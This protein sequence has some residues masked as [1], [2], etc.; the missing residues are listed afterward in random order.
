MQNRILIVVAVVLFLLAVLMGSAIFAV[1]YLTVEEPHT[2]IVAA[3][4][5]SPNT[6]LSETH[7]T[8][9]E[10]DEAPPADAI[11][12][13]R[14]L[15]GQVLVREVS[16][17]D[18]FF[19]DDLRSDY[20]VFKSIDSIPAGNRISGEMVEEEYVE[21]KPDRAVADL[22][23]LIDKMVRESIP[24]GNVVTRDQVYEEEEQVVVAARPLSA[25]RL[26]RTED[27][28]V[29]S[30]PDVP[31]DT[32]DDVEDLTGRALRQ[33][34]EAGEI[35]HGADLF[36]DDLQ[37]SFFIPSYL[38][39]VNVDVDRSRSIYYMIRPGDLIDLYIYHPREYSAEQL[40][41]LPGAGDRLHVLQKVAEA[42]EVLALSR[43]DRSIW[44]RGELAALEED[45][46][47]LTYDGMTLALTLKEA[48][49]VRLV[50][51]MKDRGMDVHFY[52][53]LRPSS[54]ETKYGL[55]KI[56]DPELFDPGMR[57]EVE[58]L[59]ESRPVEVIQGDR[60]ETHRVPKR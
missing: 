19:A 29:E 36:E 8:E 28:R 5:I 22:D 42:A 50:E 11:T 20:R 4:D 46:S 25:N 9:E 39:A 14:E 16:R 2:V 6:R 18:H 44:E 10:I 53:I 34:R 27:L 31:D 48:E 35:I 15:I 60:E 17:G 59:M 40:E 23:W 57:R 7:L 51:G 49:K 13:S 24:A 37:L 21:E 52:A 33:A 1:L 43:G 3:T 32:F 41:E 47:P 54:L 26:L 55:R 30:R 58:G 38:R 12:D 45:D 56:T